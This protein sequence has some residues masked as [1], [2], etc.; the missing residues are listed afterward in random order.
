M[1]EWHKL[2]SLLV[3]IIFSTRNREPLIPPADEPALFAYLGGIVRNHGCA[4]MAANGTA[5]H[6]HLLISMSKSVALADLL[7]AIKR[8][9]SRWLHERSADNANFSWQGGY[10]AFSIGA[11]QQAAACAYIA[12][13]KAHHQKVSFQDELQAFLRTYQVAFD[14]KYIWQ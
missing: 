8:D 2:T 12:K 14:E 11:S 4:L 1:R 6:V 5:D 7:L 3:H 9:T 10:A 13:Q